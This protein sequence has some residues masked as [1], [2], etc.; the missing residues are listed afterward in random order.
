MRDTHHPFIFQGEASSRKAL[1]KETEKEDL[2]QKPTR[3][4]IY[5]YVQCSNSFAYCTLQYLDFEC[6]DLKWL[7]DECNEDVYS[8]E[9]FLEWIN[10]DNEAT[11]YNTT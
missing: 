9:V 6:F 10:K 1:K 7:V 3:C 8:H 5:R 11:M 2:L 4:M